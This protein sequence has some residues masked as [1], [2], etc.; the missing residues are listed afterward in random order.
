MSYQPPLDLPTEFRLAL[1]CCRWAFAGD[2]DEAVRRSAAEADWV[3]FIE[4]CRR[5]RVQGLVWNALSGLKV[6]VPPPVR[7]ALSGDARTIAERGLRAARESG[8]LLGA[9][10]LASVPLLFM[11]GLALAMLAYGKPFAKMSADVDVLILPEDIVRSATV[12]QELGYRLQVP[13]TDS[14]LMRWHGLSKESV[15]RGENGLI[16][17]LH[18]RVADQPQLLRT[19][20]ASSP[21]QL[22]EIVPGIELPTFADEETFAYLCVH[23][24]SSAWFR[25]KW[26]TDF[27]ALLH[28]RTPDEIDRLYERSQE[29][30]AARAAGH[31]LLLADRLYA[32]PLGETLGKRLRKSNVSRWLTRVA[33][34]D[35]LSGEPTER[36][37]GTRTI[38][39]TQFFLM[40][41]MRYKMDE[42]GRQA[43]VAA[44]VF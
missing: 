21:R 7:I 34:D 36:P 17:E 30:G 15:W 25:L 31:A 33:L 18:H 26:I 16:L 27:A 43:R 41:G 19:L 40:P 22:V 6:D 44:G 23:G 3:R 42:L 32:I 28:A 12:L 14:Q 35:L 9:F 39:L 24:A 2:S 8:R 10:E 1:A 29:L 20:T 38:H 13:A 4:T 5:H 11:K 37:F